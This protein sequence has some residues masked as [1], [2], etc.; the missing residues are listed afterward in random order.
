MVSLGARVPSKKMSVSEALFRCI[1]QRKVDH[2]VSH[3]G[4]IMQL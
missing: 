4:I 3:S 2:G 1:K